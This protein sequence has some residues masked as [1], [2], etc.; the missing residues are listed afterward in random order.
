V[1]YPSDVVVAIP[2][3][4]SNSYFPAIAAVEM[5]YF[6]EQG[7]DAS[8]KLVAPV[9]R[10]YE[11]LR[12]GSVHFVAGSGHSML[13]AFPDWKGGKLLCAQSQGMYWFL[14]MRSDLNAKKGDV[15]IVK[16]RRIGAAPWVGMAFRHLLA[17]A[18]I[19]L[20]RDGVVIRPVASTVAANV[21]FGLAAAQALEAGEIDGFWA[22]GIGAEI[23]VRRG[24]GTVVLDVRRGDGPQGCFN[25]TLATIAATDRL[26]ESSPDTA[27]A[28][29]MAVSQAQRVLK[30]NPEAAFSIA[31]KF[32]PAAEAAMIVDVL[33]RDLPFYR[34]EISD[35]AVTG[36]NGF[37]RAMGYLTRDVDYHDVVASGFKHLWTD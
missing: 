9:E 23:A 15:D 11:A 34:T 37:A 12:D 2:D 10:A 35:V 31:E 21:N 8:V 4:I 36:M 29:V 20:E 30:A 17:N 16:G 1:P 19:D 13:S 33:R 27:A 24:V 3:I 25:Y 26:I 28:A 5:G 32:F 22:N 18:G 6:R 7:I 14:V